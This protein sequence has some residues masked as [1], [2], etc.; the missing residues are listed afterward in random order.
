MHSPPLSTGAVE[1]PGP[2]V[3]AAAAGELVVFGGAGVSRGAPSDLP[4]FGGLVDDVKGRVSTPRVVGESDDAYLGRLASGGLDVERRVRRAILRPGSGSTPLHLSLAR[5]F[6]GADRVRIVTTNYDEHFE[7]ACGRAYGAIPRV[8]GAPALPDGAAFEGVVHLHGRAVDEASRLVVTD[9][10]F[11]RAYLTDGWARNFLVRL[12]SSYVVVFVGYSHSDTILSYLA[13][14]LTAG[15][16][17]RYAL[18]EAGAPT[19]WKALGVAPV[20]YP[21]SSGHGELGRAVN[22]WARYVRRDAIEADLRVMRVIQ[23]IE[24]D[25]EIT[26]DTIP[27]VL[28]TEVRRAV[29]SGRTVDSFTRYAR[30][31]RWLG[32]LERARVLDVIFG[33]EPMGSGGKTAEVLDERRRE[34]ALADWFARW[35]VVE[36]RGEGRALVRRMGQPPA[37]LA[38]RI[39][40]R[41]HA[42]R[43]REVLAYWAPL[44]VESGISHK[45]AADFLE[46]AREHRDSATA[47]LMLDRIVRPGATADPNHFYR[48]FGDE[49]AENQTQVASPQALDDDWTKQVFADAWAWLWE[50]EEGRHRWRM[51]SGAAVGIAQGHDV[52]RTGGHVHRDWDAWGARV[53]RDDSSGIRALFDAVDAAVAGV[54]A[55]ASWIEGMLDGWRASRYPLLVQLGL[56]ASERDLAAGRCEADDVIEALVSQDWL[57]SGGVSETAELLLAAAL[58]G[59]SAEARAA[60]QVAIERAETDSD[61]MP[62]QILRVARV[63][64]DASVPDVP[65]WV[66]AVV[67]RVTERE[68]R[69][70]DRHHGERRR[71]LPPLTAEDL[72]ATPPA[73]I[74]REVDR[75]IRTSDARL[76][77]GSTAASV[78][79]VAR[80]DPEWGIAAMRALVAEQLYDSPM[81]FYVFAGS[82]PDQNESAR[83]VI[84]VLGL[85]TQIP[86]EPTVAHW[87]ASALRDGV[88]G[89]WTDE[90][91][92]VLGRVLDAALAAMDA[93]VV[94]LSVEAV[95]FRSARGRSTWSAL[96]VLRRALWEGGAQMWAKMGVEIDRLSRVDAEWV[97]TW[98]LPAIGPSPL[99]DESLWTAV[100]EIYHRPNR[101]RGLFRV[102]VERLVPLL[103]GVPWTRTVREWPDETPRKRPTPLARTVAETFA[104][105]A[106]GWQTVPVTD[107]IAPFATTAPGRVRALWIAGIAERYSGNDVGPYW[108]GWMR[109]VWDDLLESDPVPVG[110]AEA[111]SLLLWASLPGV[112]VEEAALRILRGPSLRLCTSREVDAWCERARDAPNE[113]LAVLARAVRDMATQ[114]R[115]LYTGYVDAVLAATANA[116]RASRRA[117]AN[118]L[119]A[120]GHWS[121]GQASS[122]L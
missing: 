93:D 117:F 64:V 45:R 14:G 41:A 80:R 65:D 15:A 13:R 37:R 96:D 82:R 35:F 94:E 121:G 6:G 40:S 60:V 44:L 52:H 116:S 70:S 100:S 30:D 59:A 1:L 27:A 3:D 20:I 107:W 8:W 92:H 4:L 48:A 98:V 46:A 85:C 19:N 81:W 109:D 61:A 43:D 55:Q 62:H 56:R 84:G 42:S 101:P 83:A 24:S 95:V 10:D 79:R 113:V 76:L 120:A 63:I 75:R 57:F 71:V 103:G 22:G 7:T 110:P 102:M 12:Y 39:A 34:R 26:A 118:E 69:V 77:G 54:Q 66:A 16:R 32:W 78:E 49:P 114:E 122:M 90:E 9:R 89:E 29:T 72:R 51:L 28:R 91:D 115:T 67:G 74:I 87:M 18:T 31:P 111:C 112:P 108:T 73:E 105:A 106:A 47:L 99:S 36:H 97:R 2:L 38:D 86:T 5:L 104:D 23:A 17:E 119:V 21:S 11:G 33:D 58:P 88:E 25:P 53:S 50:A 68:E